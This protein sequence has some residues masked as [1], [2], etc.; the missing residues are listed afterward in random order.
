MSISSRSSRNS[1]KTS[2]KNRTIRSWIM[3]SINLKHSPNREKSLS[4]P[5][6]TLWTSK[7][8][9]RRPKGKRPWTT[10]WLFWMPEGGSSRTTLSWTRNFPSTKW[11]WIENSPEKSKSCLT[12]GPVQ[13]IRRR[14]SYIPQDSRTLGI[15]PNKNTFQLTSP[16]RAKRSPFKP[17]SRT[18]ITFF[19][20]GNF[21]P[22]K[23]GI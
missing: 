3:A 14:Q 4:F 15:T 21:S 19:T 18:M 2:N 8:E 11:R 9:Y 17:S 6:K 12:R 7:P 23:E 5:I 13:W 1:S 22:R 10:L 16:T 20:W